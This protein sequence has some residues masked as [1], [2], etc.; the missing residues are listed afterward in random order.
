VYSG[1]NGSDGGLV[2]V[3]GKY[4]LVGLTRIGSWW[5]IEICGV[6]QCNLSLDALS[7]TRNDESS[8]FELLHSSSSAQ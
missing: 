7:G 8:I 2:A 5:S 1:L 3:K 6:A 4:K